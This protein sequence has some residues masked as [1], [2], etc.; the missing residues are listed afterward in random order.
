[1]TRSAVFAPPYYVVILVIL[2]ILVTVINKKKT[3]P[4]GTRL[5]IKSGDDLLSHNVAGKRVKRQACLSVLQ[6]ARATSSM[7]AAV[8]HAWHRR[9]VG[10]VGCDKTASQGEEVSDTYICKKTSPFGT[11]LF[12]KSGDDLLSNDI[13]CTSGP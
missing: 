6:R 4:F 13:C 10:S 2:V 7:P 3:S 9:S 11:R 1:M 5:F 12:I 8:S